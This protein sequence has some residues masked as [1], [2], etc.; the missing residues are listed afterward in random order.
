MIKNLSNF[1]G[2]ENVSIKVPLKEHTTF[3][4]GGDADIL[5]TVSSVAQLSK[6]MGYLNKCQANHFVLGNGSNIL[7]SDEGF[8][9]IVVKLAGELSEIS[10][11]G[12]KITAGAG[13]LLSNVCKI[14]ADHSLT[15]I[16]FAYGIP[17]TVGG[18][19][20]MNAGAYGGEMA[21]VVDGVEAVTKEGEAIYV[22]PHSLRFDYRKSDVKKACLTISKVVF[23]LEEGNE[24][25]IR[26]KMKDLMQR[27]IDKQPL[28]FPSAG[29]TF[30]RPKG[31]FA[32]QLIEEAGLSGERVGGACVSP[33]H[34]GFIVNDKDAT[35]SD[36]SKLI[37]I[38]KSR[39]YEHS[40]VKLETEVI[41]IGKF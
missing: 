40:N 18:A 12:N 25:E 24:E 33:K 20:V 17:G 7:V 39:V 10:V 29:S 37:D 9:G 16:E 5:V 32:G 21:M 35:A 23:K 13:A 3:K 31:Y 4:V 27:R 26:E 2:S 14:A 30:K 22:S 41:R 15:G 36:I 1:V 19:I 28:E 38:V 8:R 34:C 6:V 11:E